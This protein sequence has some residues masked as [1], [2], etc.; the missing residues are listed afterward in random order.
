MAPRPGEQMARPHMT[1]ATVFIDVTPLP[2][3][4]DS[5]EAG[6][7]SGPTARDG[8]HVPVA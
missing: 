8:R 4:R 2:N 5:K 6:I 7:A 1:S 3:G